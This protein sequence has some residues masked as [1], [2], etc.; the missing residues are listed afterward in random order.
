MLTT[1][2]A[3]FIWGNQNATF[4]IIQELAVEFISTNNVLSVC[5][6]FVI[7]PIL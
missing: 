3:T 2:K 6:E 5:Q 7:I 1:E 4:Y